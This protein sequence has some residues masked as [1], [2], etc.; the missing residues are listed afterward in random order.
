MESSTVFSLVHGDHSWV[1]NIESSQ[2]PFGI[3]LMGK[4][5]CILILAV[6]ESSFHVEARNSTCFTDVSMLSL[7]ET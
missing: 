6:A 4:S 1:V 2:K 7:I 3:G 5:V